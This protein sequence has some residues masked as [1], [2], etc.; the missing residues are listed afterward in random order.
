MGPS[1]CQKGEIIP[2]TLC[3]L[4]GILTLLRQ[5]RDILMQDPL[6]NYE[7]LPITSIPLFNSAA[8]KLV[9]RVDSLALREN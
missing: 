7:Y 6:L 8:T 3:I 1:C 5:A 2:L 9:L 4:D